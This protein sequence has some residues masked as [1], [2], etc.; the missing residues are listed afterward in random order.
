MGYSCSRYGRREL[1]GN[2]WIRSGHSA[3]AGRRTSGRLGAGGSGAPGDIGRPGPQ[4]AAS[5]PWARREPNSI[6]G[7]PLAARTMRLAFGGDEGLVVQAQEHEGLNKLGSMPGPWTVRMAPWE[8][9]P[10]PQAPPRCPGEA[11]M[12]QISQKFLVKSSLFAGE[13]LY[14]PDQR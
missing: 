7:R 3:M 9:P 4:Q 8:R 2:I 10:C 11:E 12:L 14:P 1:V 5:G 13:N 6:T